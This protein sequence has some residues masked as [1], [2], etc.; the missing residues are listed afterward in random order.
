MPRGSPPRQVVTLASLV[1]KETARRE[2]RPLVA[3]VYRNR[4]KIGMG[5]Q[6]DPTVIYA[7]QQ[8]GKYDGNLSRDD[9]QFDSPYNTYRYS[10]LPPGPIAAPGLASIEA[11][12]RPAPVAHLYF[13]SR[14]DGSHVFADTLD[15]AQSQRPGVAGALLPRTPESLAAA[16][17]LDARRH[18]RHVP[19]VADGLHPSGVGRGRRVQGGCDEGL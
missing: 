7:L 11:V 5:M 8:A 15:A 6:A 17:R 19:V 9:L 18:R 13:V 1:E 16:R 4:L 10:G 12:L 14:N 3:A 2:E